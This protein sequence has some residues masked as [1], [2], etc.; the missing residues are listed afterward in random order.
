[1][2]PRYTRNHTF[3]TN[4]GCSI[5]TPSQQNHVL[6]LLLLLLLPCLLLLLSGT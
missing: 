2:A 4:G 5:H 1:M 3:A 6:L